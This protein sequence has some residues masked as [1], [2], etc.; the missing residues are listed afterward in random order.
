MVDLLEATEK[1]K[2]TKAAR[3]GSLGGDYYRGAGITEWNHPRPPLYALQVCLGATCACADWQVAVDSDRS[4]AV[5]MNFRA[6]TSGDSTG[7]E[8]LTQSG[9]RVME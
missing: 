3:Q 4:V 9:M 7:S 8:H 6:P 5:E 2:Q 1:C